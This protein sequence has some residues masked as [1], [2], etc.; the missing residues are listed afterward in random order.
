MLF[1]SH[2]HARLLFVLTSLNR[3]ADRGPAGWRRA[4]SGESATA[5]SA[6]DKG[7]Q[8]TE[9]AGHRVGPLERDL[10]NG[11]KRL[12]FP[13]VKFLWNGLIV[14]IGKISLERPDP[15][16]CPGASTGGRKPMT[17]RRQKNEA[18]T[19][20]RPVLH[21]GSGTVPQRGGIS[22]ILREAL[23]GAARWAGREFV[24]LRKGVPW[25]GPTRRHGRG[26]SDGGRR[27]IL[28]TGQNT[29]L[30]AHSGLRPPFTST[31]ERIRFE[32]S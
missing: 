1:D 18:R 13:L 8:A 30:P 25:P 19:R 24:C 20:A 31:E 29:V 22:V 15:M 12:L 10:T 11:N 17:V 32:R 6:M 14:T 21:T 27:P 4:K 5:R 7:Q 9:R 3:P 2:C 16:S 23:A 28:S 26:V